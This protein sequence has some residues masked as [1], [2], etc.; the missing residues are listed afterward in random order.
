MRAVSPARAASQ[1]ASFAACD[2]CASAT[3]A[4]AAKTHAIDANVFIAG[5]LSIADGECDERVVGSCAGGHD[6]ELL[7]R[8]GAIG[9]R[10]RRHRIWNLAP[11]HFLAGPGFKR[12]EITVAAADEDEAALGDE[13]AAQVAGRS[14]TVRQRHASEQRV[15]ANRRARFTER[16]LPRNLA[17]I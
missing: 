12:V 15:I 13:R 6:D 14:K 9:H 5:S 10:V 7:A 16:H 3:V 1:S 4:T 17:A 2:P 11:P 8:R